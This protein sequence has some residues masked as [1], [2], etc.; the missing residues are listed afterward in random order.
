MLHTER[1]LYLQLLC[2]VNR[3]SFTSL[4]SQCFPFDLVF[5]VKQYGW[6]QIQKQEFSAL[7]L[8][9][10]FEP[11]AIF[12][13]LFTDLYLCYLSKYQCRVSVAFRSEQSIWKHVGICVVLIWFCRILRQ[14]R[15]NIRFLNK[16]FGTFRLRTVF[17]TKSERLYG[18]SEKYRKI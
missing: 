10:M 7:T 13:V 9:Q 15:W 17:I 5:S 6:K 16:Y 1:K 2:I 4:K 12:T 8:L 18:E 11:S 3:Y 14:Q